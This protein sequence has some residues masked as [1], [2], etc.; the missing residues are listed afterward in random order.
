M[1]FTNSV[2]DVEEFIDSKH[3]PKELDGEEDW[4]YKYVEPVPGENDRMKDIETRDRILAERQ[5]Q[6]RDFESATIRWI[7]NPDGDEGKQVKAEREA[8]AS[9]LSIG[10][11]NLDP[12]VRARSLYDRTGVIKPGGKVDFYPAADEA[13]KPGGGPPAPAIYDTSADD[14]D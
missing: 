12:Y 5:Q 14:V 2:K 7:Q 10:Y 8:V 9:K 11:W 3:I 13:S 4:E 1:N 6:Y